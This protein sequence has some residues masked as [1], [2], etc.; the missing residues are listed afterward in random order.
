MNNDANPQNF[1][2]VT[3]AFSCTGKYIARRLLATGRKVKTLTGHPNRPDPF[4]GKVSVAPL[5]FSRPEELASNLHGAGTLYNTYWIRFAHGSLTYPDAVANSQ[6]LFRAARAAG[7]RRIVHV[8]IANPSLDSPLPYYSGKARVE[9]ALVASG[10][11]YAIL[12]PTVIFGDEDILI[13]NI[14][15]LVRRFPVFAIPGKGGYR[16]QPIFVEDFSELAVRA[17][18]GG[19][20]TVADAVGPETYTFE[21]LVQLVAS[22]VGRRARF[23]HMNPWLVHAACSLLSVPLRDVLLTREEIEGLMADLLVSRQAP[24]GRTRLNDW[25]FRNS[26]RVGTSYA[27]ELERHYR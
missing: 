10:L 19:E 4:E 1:D 9:E 7:V 22:A 14:A 16:L 3:G 11:S 8:S 20:N 5:D 12:R 18:F 21:D 17:G 13:N 24:A 27:S 25:L 2:V 15:W 23:V 6:A 26:S